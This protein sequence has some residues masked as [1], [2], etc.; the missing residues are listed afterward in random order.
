MLHDKIWYD[1]VG[2]GSEWNGMIMSGMV[3]PKEM[4]IQ[5]AWYGIWYGMKGVQCTTAGCWWYEC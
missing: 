5:M 1:H 3:V 4:V 2:Y